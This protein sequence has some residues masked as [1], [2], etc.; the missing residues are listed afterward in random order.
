MYQK[1]IKTVTF[2]IVGIIS[3]IIGLLFIIKNVVLY[4]QILKLLAIIIF[5]SGLSLLIKALFNAK[6][7]IKLGKAIL[8]MVLG[9]GMLLFPKIPL[10]LLPLLFSF[11]V[12]V[13]AVIQIVYYFFLKQ[14]QVSG[15][16]KELGKAIFYILLA[17]PFLLAPL[18]NLKYML[19][20]VGVYLLLYGMT[21]IYDFLEETL[22]LKKNKKRKFRISLPIFITAFIPYSV[23]KDI[24]E[25]SLEMAA[26]KKMPKKNNE[27]YNLEVLVHVSPEGSGTIGH[28]DIWFDNRV[29]SYGNYDMR[30]RKLK[31]A[32]GDGVLFTCKNK[33][34]YLHFCQKHSK[35]LLF[36]F[37]LQLNEEQEKAVREEIARLEENLYE[38]IPYYKRALDNH[39]TITEGMYE[40]YASTLY[41][42]THAKF[43]KFK[44]GKFKTFFILSTNCVALADQIVG[45]AGTDIVQMSG[46]IAPGT[47]YDYLY[48]EYCKKNSIVV[49]YNVYI[50]DE[51]DDKSVS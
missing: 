23:F 28:V 21:S 34:E 38:W 48:R 17:L 11:Y 40:D 7:R 15:R 12:L 35:K 37:G 13:S 4:E 39:E 32:I 46:L 6:E 50:G 30:S 33:E 42:M 16:I 44:T 20:I 29:I 3:F 19:I 43:Y 2:L 27:D 8:N 45:A 14:N 22:P 18:I 24:N 49:A 26:P 25:S 36:G 47:Y 51:T 1:Y 41:K 9:F 10:S 31:E 5:I